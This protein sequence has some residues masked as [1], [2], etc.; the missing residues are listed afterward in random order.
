MDRWEYLIS[1]E[2]KLRHHICEYY[3]NNVDAIIDIGA[4]KYT[5]PWSNVFAIDPLASIDGSFHGTVSE[6]MQQ[7]F[8]FSLNNCGVMALGLEITGGEEEWKA[9]Q[10]LIESSKI[11]II[12]HSVEHTPSVW[13]FEEIMR[14]TKKNLITLIDFELCHVETPGF[15]PHSKRR[16]VVLE[17]K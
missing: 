12:E 7:P 6:W 4:Y 5:L 13:Q 1:K 9:F 16:L 8:C 15:I 11:A 17:K 3:L 10:Y 2:Y 14:T